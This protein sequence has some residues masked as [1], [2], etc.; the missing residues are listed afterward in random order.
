MRA[1]RAVLARID[2][3][4]IDRLFVSPLMI[5]LL[6]QRHV[7]QPAR[8]DQQV[9]GGGRQRLDRPP[10]RR[11]PRPVDVDAVNLVDLGVRDRPG[12]RALADD[13]AP[14]ARAPR[15]SGASNRRPPG[16]ACRGA[17]MTAAAA[18]GPA[19]GLIPASSTPATCA[20]PVVHS[21]VSK[22][23]IVRSR[24]PSARL[25]RRRRATAARI[26]RA[27]AAASAASAASIAAGSGAAA[28]HVARPQIRQ[29]QPARAGRERGGAR[30]G[31]G[32]SVARAVRAACGVGA[33]RRQLEVLAVFVARV[34]GWSRACL[35]VGD[36]EVRVGEALVGD[37]RQVRE[38]QRLVD[39]VRGERGLGAVVRSRAGSTSGRRGRLRGACASGPGRRSSRRRSARPGRRRR[40]PATARCRP[41]DRG[42]RVVAR[43]RAGLGQP[44][45]AP[46]ARRPPASGASSWTS[47]SLP[48]AS[49]RASRRPPAALGPRRC[50]GAVMTPESPA[51][52]LPSRP[53]AWTIGR[54]SSAA[55]AAASPRAPPRAG[56]R[57][58]PRPRPRAAKCP[59]DAPA[60]RLGLGVAAR[61]VPFLALPS[62]SWRG[63]KRD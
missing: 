5:A 57:R 28:V 4:A 11:Q 3:A 37:Q 25:A 56:A 14:A 38:L 24:C 63:R 6:R 31:H 43:H 39:L 44:A 55:A 8:V 41:G 13:R 26:A 42:A 23:S 51:A 18:T 21:A 50:S 22:R 53:P 15:R 35:H 46:P 2:A 60:P 58:R 48:E 29:R 49:P 59:A 20:T 52:A 36:D 12:E 30:R 45:R 19:S 40:R 9:L 7:A 34:G 16:C 32:G 17:K 61:A 27:P 33:E 10:H 1:S 54:G 62:T 47:P